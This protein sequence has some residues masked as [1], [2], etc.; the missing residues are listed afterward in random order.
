MGLT[1]FHL[2]LRAIITINYSWHT[3]NSVG[4]IYNYETPALNLFWIKV[5]DSVRLKMQAANINLK[6]LV[7]QFV[8]E[9]ILL[10][11]TTGW[12]V[13]LICYRLCLFFPSHIGPRLT[14]VPALKSILTLV[15]A[16]T[17]RP[18]YTTPI[19][20]H[21]SSLLFSKTCSSEFRDICSC[22]KNYVT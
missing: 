6:I 12:K 22:Y 4:I 17:L 9:L 7:V 15:V 5:H 18:K 3:I 11:R 8:S 20:F 21:V 1:N 19:L 13:D 2:L 14:A 16:A 10:R